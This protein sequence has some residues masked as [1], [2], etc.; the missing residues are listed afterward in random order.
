MMVSLIKGL[1]IRFGRTDGSHIRKIWNYGFPLAI[2]NMAMWG[3][4]LSDRYLIAL[5]RPES[6]VGLY[7]AAYN[8]SGKSI[9]ILAAL[10]G[11]STFPILVKIW[12]NEGREATE[13]TLALFTR[14]YLI[15][16]IPAATGL[17]LFASPF[18]SLFAAEAYHEGYR[19]VG[20]VAFSSFFWE[21]TLIAGFGLLIKKKTLAIAANQIITA[22]INIGLNLLLIPRYGFVIAGITTLTGYL[23]LFILQYFSSRRYLTWRFPYKS[24]RNILTATLLMG[25]LA[26]WIYGLSGSRTELRPGYFLFSVA[27]AIP[28]YFGTLW[29]LGELNEFERGVAVRF[30]HRLWA[31]MT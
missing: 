9:E 2:G 18:V 23:A 22:L 11:L 3:L 30:Y 29:L 17:C 25:S 5:F 7:S 28:V 31:R 13:N 27:L 21:L 26:F 19:V 14:L 16:G 8:L 10:F 1:D 4:R 12:E 6:E 24:L 20:P 15:L